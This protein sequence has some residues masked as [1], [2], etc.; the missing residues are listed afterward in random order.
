MT[1]QKQYDWLRE[2]P[3]GTRICAKK[4]IWIKVK[5]LSGN[6]GDAII[7]GMCV[8]INS[9]EMVHYSHLADEQNPPRQECYPSPFPQEVK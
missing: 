6:V 5:S 7:S 8:N 3:Q 1:K 2:L 9:G 4:G